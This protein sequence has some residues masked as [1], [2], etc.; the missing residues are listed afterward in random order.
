[1]AVASPIAVAAVRA[2][3]VPIHTSMSIGTSAVSHNFAHA[4]R[5]KKPSRAFVRA[6]GRG[7]AERGET[8]TPGGRRWVCRAWTRSSG[9]F[10][11]LGLA[12]LRYWRLR[13]EVVGEALHGMDAGVFDGPLRDLGDRRVGH[14]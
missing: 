9:F 3:F 1:M 5:K 10:D 12:L 7:K 11:G 4:S 13:G 2:F 14:A 8:T 6:R